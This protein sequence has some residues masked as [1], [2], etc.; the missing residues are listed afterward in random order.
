MNILSSLILSI[1]AVLGTFDTHHNA[2][3]T[4]IPPPPPPNPPPQFQTVQ[5][6]PPVS[7]G[8]SSGSQA[9][10]PQNQP[11]QAATTLSISRMSR[12]PS[13]E[14]VMV[15]DDPT[16]NQLWSH[17]Y[18]LTEE[19]LED[20]P[21][22]P[23]RRMLEAFRGVMEEI[24][25]PLLIDAANTALGPRGQRALVRDV[26]KLRKRFSQLGNRRNILDKHPEYAALLEYFNKHMADMDGQCTNSP[27]NRAFL[28]KACY[29][30][31]YLADF[32]LNGMR[33]ELEEGS[34]LES[35]PQLVNFQDPIVSMVDTVTK[36]I[37]KKAKS[38][39]PSSGKHY[40]REIKGTVLEQKEIKKLE[41]FQSAMKAKIGRRG[42]S[43]GFSSTTIIIVI[44]T[45]LVIVVI[46]IAVLVLM[47]RNK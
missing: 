1:P 47:R 11:Q 39:K 35:N 44:V 18:S 4:F 26:E 43:E 9:F 10:T 12:S 28:C 2:P 25:A 19:L 38:V 15:V 20:H 27:P 34:D 3:P 42:D 24:G 13:H 31:A 16:C 33:I 37:K 41:K 21:D 46:L 7:I 22:S 45:I 40:Q 6:P 32:I 29:L 30:P 36:E 14:Q 5:T 8:P 17:V 23:Y